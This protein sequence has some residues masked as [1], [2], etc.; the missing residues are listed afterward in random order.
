MGTTAGRRLRVGVIGAR[1]YVG[2]EL[3]RILW[4][5]PQLTL[6]FVSSRQLA[7]APLSEVLPEATDAG[8]TIESLEPEEAASR[9]VD[10]LFL[11]LPNGHAEPY[12]AAV[13]RACPDALVV[14]LSADHRFT[15]TFAYGLPE[16]HRARLIGARRI[17]NPGCYATCAQLALE[18]LRELLRGPPSI[19]GVSGYSGA[20]TAPSPR[21]DVAALADNLIPYA[22]AGHLHEREISHHLGHAVRFMPHVAP[23]FRGISLTIDCELSSAHDASAL[24]RRFADRYANE[25]LVTVSEAPPL[26]RDAVGRH[27]VQLGGITTLGTRAVVVATLDNLLKGAATQA[28]QNLNVA[29]GL[30]EFAAIS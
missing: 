1:G 6:A 3:L 13:D 14:D 7:G 5:H 12:V 22:L 10:A 25:P 15:A 30:P 16:H 21:N 19:F 29:F 23:F 18:P 20:G 27:G 9:G 26:V 4:R 24:A 2:A 8:V 11:A 17:A 28:V